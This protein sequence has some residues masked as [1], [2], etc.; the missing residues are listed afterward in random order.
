MTGPANVTAVPLGIA[1]S[2]LT[3]TA[4]ASE[5][6]PPVPS[7][8]AAV[9]RQRARPQ[10][11]VDADRQRPLVERDPAAERAVASQHHS[12]GAVLDDLSRAAHGAAQA[13]PSPGCRS[14]SVLRAQATAP[15][16]VSGPTPPQVCAAGER[17]WHAERSA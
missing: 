4:L 11:G 9:D 13:K 14:V 6:L 1:K 10:A 7:I 17:Q 15:P 2:L 8:A 16:I 12:P 5:R 3:I